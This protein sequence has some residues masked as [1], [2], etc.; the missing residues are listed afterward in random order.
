[1]PTWPVK[2]PRSDFPTKDYWNPLQIKNKTEKLEILNLTDP[3]LNLTWSQRRPCLKSLR[4]KIELKYLNSIMPQTLNHIWPDM[5][6]IWP[7]K[8]KWPDYFHHPQTFGT[9]TNQAVKALTNIWP[10]QDS[11][12]QIRS[13]QSLHTITEWDHYKRKQY[14]KVKSTYFLF[15]FSS[16]PSLGFSSA[17]MTVQHCPSHASLAKFSFFPLRYPISLNSKLKL[18]SL[19]DIQT[20]FKNMNCWAFYSYSAR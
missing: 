5:N 15:G 12:H 16:S 14:E 19:N 2:I 1:M 4:Q 13:H 10:T 20:Y 18:T 6:P 9:L 11:I 8:W 7:V 3:F 17:L